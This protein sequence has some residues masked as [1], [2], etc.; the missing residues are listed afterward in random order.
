MTHKEKNRQAQADG[1]V[2]DVPVFP[3]IAGVDSSASNPT[4]ASDHGLMGTKSSQEGVLRME[5]SILQGN[6]GAG[7]KPYGKERITWL[8]HNM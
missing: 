4:L 8:V 3:A 2:E 7:Q 1:P 6:H 5:A